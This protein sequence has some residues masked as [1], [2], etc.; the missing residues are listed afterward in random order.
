VAAGVAVLTLIAGAILVGGGG[1]AQAATP[2][3]IFGSATPSVLADSD[4][5]KVEL[6]VQFKAAVAGQVTGVRF[7]KGS[8]NKGTHTGSLWSSTGTKLAGATFTGETASGWQQVLFAAPVSITAGTVYTASYVAPQGRYSVNNP[9][10]F[11]KTT[12]DLTAVKGTYKY[13]GGYPNSVY[14]T[15]NYWV[16]VLF[17]PTV[18]PTTT[19]ATTTPVSTTPVTTTPVSTTPVTTTDPTTTP[20]STT[21]VTTT[22]TTTTTPPPPSFPDAT[23][24]GYRNAPGYPGA[25]TTCATPIQSNTTYRFCDFGSVDVGSTGTQAVNV[26]FYGC[27]FKAA[28][29]KLV[30]LWGDNISF[31]Y[32]SFEPNATFV[33]DT[34]SP[35]ATSYQYG[36][37]ADGSYNTHVAQLTVTHSDFWGFGNA[38]DINGSTQAKPQV[39]RDNW[40]HDAADDNNATYHTDGIGSLN[41]GDT[42]SYA[43]LDHNTIVSPG[44][45]NG[46]AFQQGSYDHFTITNNLIS[47]WGYAVAVWAPAPYTT[48]TGNVW[49]TKLQPTFGP[50]Y[51]QSFWTSTGS[52]WK[53]NRWSVP[54]GSYGNPA[55]DGKFW[56]PDGPSSI[57]Y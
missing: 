23:N 12:G 25:L 41:P 3:T 13:G 18:V 49:S 5:V 39:F 46:I 6:G 2:A 48:F 44:N 55:D 35:F 9:Y 38:I 33:P 26:S 51:P 50:L 34:R 37:V 54:A 28:T 19:P 47:G 21:P 11:P 14:Q 17:N 10:T 16:D 32:S 8:A 4:A 56:T 31:D 7:Y 36:I 57:D 52:V 29:D 40:I 53:D 22:A 27:R 42:G 20:V 43:V 24:T 1:A 30:G 15:S 45:T